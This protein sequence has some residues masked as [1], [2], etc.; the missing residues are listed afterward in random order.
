M[1]KSGT[2]EERLAAAVRHLALPADE[3]LAQK[4]LSNDPPD[5]WALEFDDLYTA[6]VDRLLAIPPEGRLEALQA[7]DATL[8]RMSGSAN[9]ELW[10]P[11]AVRRDPRWEEVRALARN[12]LERF[13]WPDAA[14]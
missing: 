2:L 13:D 11:A 10:T 9:A 6:Y 4:P 3:A 7:L 8:T 5:E 1:T 14:D 12:V